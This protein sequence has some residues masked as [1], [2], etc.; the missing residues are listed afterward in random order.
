VKIK[1]LVITLF[2]FSFIHMNITARILNDREWLTKTYLASL[3]GTILFVGVNYY[4][5][6]Y[7][8]Y[9]KTPETYETIDT[10]PERSQFGS[11]YKHHTGDFLTFDPGYKYDHICLF[12]IMGHYGENSKNQFYNIDTENSIT[13]ALEHATKLLKIGGTLQVGP[14]KLSVPQFNTA[15][16]RARFRKYPLD[17]YS[18]IS[19]ELG[20]C[21]MLWWGKKIR[22]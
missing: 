12:G 3:E 21:N 1:T 5:A 8:T 13:Q 6:D 14:N 19:N 17:K 7:H 18:V 2:I 20:A 4:N 15:Y 11:P 10:I 16:W 22:D 9:V